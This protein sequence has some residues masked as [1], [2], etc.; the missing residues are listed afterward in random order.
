MSPK[1]AFYVRVST[2]DKQDVTRQI[3]DLHRWVGTDKMLG[4]DIDVYKES[5]SGYKDDRQELER[6]V[7]KI[8]SDTDYYKCIYIT[9][10][11]R[12]GRSPRKVREVLNFLEDNKVNLKIQNPEITLLND[13]GKRH[14]VGSLILDIMMY[15]A[16]EEVR[17][18]KQRSRS[19]ILS[20]MKAGK[21]GGGKFKPYGYKKGEDKMMVIH[22]KEA[23]TVRAIFDYY[24][25][26]KGTKWIANKL[27]E[28]GIKTRTNKSFE[29]E[30]IN[31][32]LQKYGRD[33]VWSDKTV[34]DILQNPIYKGKRRYY[35]G[36][37]KL[38]KSERTVEL[39]DTKTENIIEPEL[40]EDCMEIR[41]SK[42]H[43]N[44][45]TDYTYLLKGKIICG[46]CGRNYFAKYKPTQ[47][48]D[49]VYI[50]SSR[51]KKGGNCGN[52]GINIS[53]IESAIFNE[54][55]DSKSLLK[56]INTKDKIRNNIEVTIARLKTDIAAN[57]RL[58]GECEK[59]IE[60]TIDLLIQSNT[61]NNNSRTE[62]FKKR[63]GK[64]ESELGR[65]EK[66]LSSDG[67][68]LL[69]H[70]AALEVRS[71]V[72]TTSDML[73][74]YIDDRIKLR[75]VYIQF[76]DKVIINSIDSNSA[77]AS[78]FISLNGVRLPKSLKLILDISG[79]RKR[80]KVFRYLS[81]ADMS[82]EPEYDEK[83]ILQTNIEALQYEIG[84]YIGNSKNFGED[85]DIAGLTEYEFTPILDKYVLTIPPVTKDSN[86]PE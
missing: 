29:N 18:L 86:A 55:V 52:S 42:T 84:M 33:V 68:H 15:L 40:W 62:I 65:I 59:Q 49:K 41:Q 26:G 23:D 35:G 8:S 56:H 9:E 39:L 73:I 16:D 24:K 60:S 79:I 43:R 27:N 19:G 58:S 70:E 20:S 2:S 34:D 83:G 44:Y 17:Y 10:I 61:T 11:S 14:G 21:I 47:H 30:I 25:S 13:E 81:M 28:L 80:T 3:E 6:L 53:L 12:L 22:Q 38:K 64:L 71:D 82:N 48:G 57:Q 51:L 5:I 78:V 32:R 74:D 76:I 75:E 77:L 63:L 85:D 69:K 72:Q 66:R 50:C 36:T 4:E 45:L 54:M 37:S 31:S 1:F 46:C 7:N 67:R